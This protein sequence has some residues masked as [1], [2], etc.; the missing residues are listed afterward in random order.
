MSQSKNWLQV[1]YNNFMSIPVDESKFNELSSK[2]K[3]EKRK[4]RQP[5]SP[6]VIYAK[7]VHKLHY[8]K[9]DMLEELK[10]VPD[11]INEW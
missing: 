10:L 4:E 5:E 2:K 11:D 7:I 8:G 9:L 3:G 1:N 6:Q